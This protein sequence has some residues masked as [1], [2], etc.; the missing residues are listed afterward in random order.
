MYTY[1]SLKRP[2]E[3]EGKY[4]FVTSSFPI[5]TGVWELGVLHAPLS[6]IRINYL[7]RMCECKHE[8]VTLF[9][10]S[11]NFFADGIAIT[12]ELC[13]WICF[14]FNVKSFSTLAIHVELLFSHTVRCVRIVFA[15]PEPNA[16]LSIYF[17]N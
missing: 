15:Q 3:R 6:S 2:K 8:S 16:K 13:I 12:L 9:G 5:I 7:V 17:K 14:V 1:F 10:R 11:K 4:G